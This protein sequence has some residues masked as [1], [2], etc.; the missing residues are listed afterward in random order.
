MIKREKSD[1]DEIGAMWREEKIVVARVITTLCEVMMMMRRV[2]DC[3]I[4]FKIFIQ[5]CVI[6]V[7]DFNFNEKWS[8][9]NYY[10]Y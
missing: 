7:G 2:N 9:T 4:K 1:E 10:G 5:R 6:F 8:L 3:M